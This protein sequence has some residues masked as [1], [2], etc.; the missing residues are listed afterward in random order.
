MSPV[1]ALVRRHDRDRFQTAL[2]APAAHREALFALYAFNY[3]IARVRDLVR[4]PMLGRIRLQWWRE[5]VSAAFAGG[6]IRRH[7][8]VV[9]LAS[10]IRDR[11][12]TREYFERLIAAR[13]ADLDARSPA[14]LAVL[15]AYCEASSACLMY[16]A[17]E[18]LGLADPAALAAIRHVGTAYG[19]A[20]MLRA[21]PFHAAAGRGVIPEEIAAET[22]LDIRDYRARRGSP[23][24]VR[25]VAAIAE[26][27]HSRLA[28]GR[29]QRRAIPRSALPAVLPAVVAGRY[30][31]RL[32]R[33]GYNPFDPALAVP[34]PLQSWRLLAAA[35]RNRF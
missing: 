13:E 2:F 1:G 26:A 18:I 19:L 10:T 3:E 31:G 21:L 9:P 32:H 20:G 22:R 11:P 7:E 4:E 6:P 34:D 17:A 16:L 28:A 14:S 5:A 12:M 27:A 24:L 23:A 29:K 8:V 35:L 15:E 25:A 30:L 33:A